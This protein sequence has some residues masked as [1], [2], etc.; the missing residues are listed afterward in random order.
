MKKSSTHKFAMDEH[1]TPA[2]EVVIGHTPVEEEDQ[3]VYRFVTMADD[4]EIPGESVYFDSPDLNLGDVVEIELADGKRD[5][6]TV[7]HITQ[8][9]EEVAGITREIST[10]HLI[11]AR[12]SLWKTMLLLAIL[13]AGWYVIDFILH[14]LF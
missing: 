13:A 5:Y 1:Q 14:H 8:D 11:R 6:L 3:P 12:S 7:D 9:I 4:S 10:V 2:D